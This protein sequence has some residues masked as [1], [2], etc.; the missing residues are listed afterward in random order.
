MLFKQGAELMEM[1]NPNQ[2]LKHSPHDDPIG[3]GWQQ[4]HPK[5]F[6]SDYI[7]TGIMKLYF[8]YWAVWTLQEI[9]NVNIEKI[10]AGK[11]CRIT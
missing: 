9:N 11:V 5:L 6:L 3:L 1:T 10:Y 4:C 7:P 2:R 8:T